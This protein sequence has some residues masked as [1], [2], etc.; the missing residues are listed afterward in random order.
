M[1]LVN[2][3]IAGRYQLKR[4]IGQGGMA[5]VY[6]AEDLILGRTVAVK[7]MRSSL[8][9]DPVYVTRFHREASA[10]AALSHKNIV[11][12]YDVG[13]EK[14]DYYIVM[15][16]VPGQTLKEL[17]HKR[18][19]LHYVEAVDIMKQVVSATAKAHA[20]GII[21]RDLK[22]QN[23]MVTDSGV[24]KIGDFGI[25]SIQSLSQVTQTDTIMGSLHYLAPEIARGEKATAQSDIY[26]LGIVFYELLRGEVPFNGESPVNIALKHMRDEI[27]SVRA[28]NP[29]IPQ[30]VENIIMK[31]TAKN[32]K[33]RY[34]SAS[35]MLDD[36]NHCLEA[37]HMNDE[38]ITFDYQEDEDLATIV[39]DDK[40]F[41]T[42]THTHLPIE[43]E[44]EEKP[45]SRSHKKMV[46]I[47]GASVV[48]VLVILMALY[49]FVMKPSQSFEMP[50]VLNLNKDEAV[51]LLEEKDLKVSDNIT[52]E[53][54][55]DVEEG[56]VIS[57]DPVARTQVKKGDE[58]SLVVS[59]GQYIVIEDYVGKDYDS[60]ASQLE[61]LGFDV[62]KEEKIDEKS[63]GTILE[64][65]LEV[66]K[67]IDPNSDDKSI[68]L[69]VSQGYSAVV[70]NV[71][72]QDIQKAK[73]ILEEA[74]FVVELNVLDPPTS[75]EEIKTM[76]INVVERQSLDAFT[77]VYKKGEK[78]TLDYYNTKPEIPETPAENT[79][80][81]PETNTPATSQ[82]SENQTIT[83][84]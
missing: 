1:S 59:S 15:E 84:Q 77:T 73:S 57:S 54:S 79:P 42:Q 67:K 20:I 52:Y 31:A 56:K 75:V 76:K 46:M 61:D 72:G 45:S 51:T 48:A 63:K 40:D 44:K 3:T 25:A 32:I 29:S 34:L 82:P 13:D 5:D 21:H 53:L 83:N 37:E 55:D 39:A 62:K 23:I 19:A 2:K 69:T 35:D 10:A 80:T 49:F 11:E 81:T 26:A 4:L 9:G 60:V 24:V 78:I 14:D 47:I 65:S 17:I 28:F 74:G 71:Y 33:D 41:F 66:G 30:S 38:K 36:L 58:V 68:T 50:D 8:T 64:Q 43:E 16:Y 12:I 6:E 22:P 7:I 27:P 18:G 70:P